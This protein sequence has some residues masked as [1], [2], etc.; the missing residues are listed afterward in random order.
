MSVTGMIGTTEMV[1]YD[2]GG[3]RRRGSGEVHGEEWP[4]P[5][6]AMFYG[7]RIRGRVW[8]GRLVSIGRRGPERT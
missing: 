2:G 5:G 7:V 3:T 8:T 4:D 6:E 1:S